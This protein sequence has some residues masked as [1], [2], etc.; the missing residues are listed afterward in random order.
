MS[1]H[2]ICD[3][4]E[5]SVDFPDKA[6]I[7]SFGRHSQFDAYADD[8]SV[9]VRLVP[10]PCSHFDAVSTESRELTRLSTPMVALERWVAPRPGHAASASAVGSRH[11]PP[12]SAPSTSPLRI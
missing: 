12:I 8:D 1:L 5:V 4:A 9:A 6:Y 7:G 11:G 10:Q 2:P 3:K